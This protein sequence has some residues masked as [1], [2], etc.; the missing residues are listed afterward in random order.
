MCIRDRPR[1]APHRLRRV[2]HQDVQRAARRHR[3]RQ[4]HHL[5]RI[6][7]ID[8]DHVQPVDPVRAVRHRGEPPHRVVREPGRDRQVGAVPQQPQRDVHADL[9]APAGE[10]RPPAGQIGP[11]I[12]PRVVQRGTVRAELVVERVHHGVALLAHVTPARLLQHTRG[13]PDGRALQRNPGGLVVDPPR[14]PGRGRLGHRPI[15]VQHGLPP[16]L[17]PLNLRGLEQPGRRAPQ[18]H[19]IRMLHRQTLRLGQNSEADR[20]AIRVHA[21]GRVTAGHPLLLPHQPHYRWHCITRA[22]IDCK[23]TFLFPV[24][25]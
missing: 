13:G 18:R 8:A 10:Q 22:P 19:R 15:I 11:R 14:R 12:P 25:R 20:Q 16:V 4:A 5:R 17:T 2:V 9:G 7:Q 24:R 3:I 21:H 1:G 6:P 23:I